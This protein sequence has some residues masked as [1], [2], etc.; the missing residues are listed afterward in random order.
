MVVGCLRV[1]QGVLGYQAFLAE[2]AVLGG[3]ADGAEAVEEFACRDEAFGAS[4]EQYGRGDAFGAVGLSETEQGS[5]AGAAAH[6][7]RVAALD[8]EAVA[9]RIDNVHR[10]ALFEG[11]KLASATSYNLD[12]QL[13]GGGFGIEVVDGDRATQHDIAAVFYL[14][15]HK[16][17]R[18]NGFKFIGRPQSPCEIVLAVLSPL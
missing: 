3:E 13:Q 14:D 1:E 17:A 8:A 6:E 16:L 11:G 7:E 15:L 2:G 12:E 5:N 18:A 9:E 4:A 10:V